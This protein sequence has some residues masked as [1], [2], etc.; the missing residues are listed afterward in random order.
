M[1]HWIVQCRCWEA[2]GCFS[3][4]CCVLGKS[5]VVAGKEKGFGKRRERQERGD[6][7]ENA[8][9]R[10][11]TRQIGNDGLPGAEQGSRRALHE[12]VFR[13]CPPEQTFPG[14]S[15][16]PTHPCSSRRGIPG[17]PHPGNGL[18]LGMCRGRRCCRSSF[19]LFGSSFLSQNP[20]QRCCG[21]SAPGWCW[22]LVGTGSRRRMN[23]PGSELPYSWTRISESL[24]LTPGC[25]SS[26]P[27]PPNTPFPTSNP[28]FQTTGRLRMRGKK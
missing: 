21:C 13:L 8:Q 17:T 7:L 3:G 1:H 14:G 24:L 9:E 19:S 23:S 4:I 10:G 5:S 22:S 12:E 28:C 2:H 20:A 26:V 6:V 11:H 18:G 16:I 27:F 25:V 15:S